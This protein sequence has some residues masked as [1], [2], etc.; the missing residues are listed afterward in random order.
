MSEG[1]PAGQALGPVMDQALDWHIRQRSGGWDGAEQAAFDAWRASDPAH[2]AAWRSVSAVWSS[3]QLGQAARL[4]QARLAPSSPAVRPR[5]SLPGWPWRRVSAIAAA[6]LVAAWIGWRFDLPT[7]LQADLVTGTG[8]Q[9]RLTLEDGSRLVLDTG[10]AIVAEMSGSRRRVRLLKGAA[11]FEVA[12]EQARPFEVRAGSAQVQ[13][14][15]T[16]FTVRYL[17]GRVTVAVRRGAVL[18]GRPGGG[19]VRLTAS[20]QVQVDAEG[21]G[22]VEGVDA[23]AAMAWVDG[24]LVFVDQPLRDVLSELRRYHPGLIILGDGRLGAARLTGNYRLDDPVQ[25]LASLAAILH[26]RM[27]RLTDAVLILH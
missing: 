23:A 10:T 22:P 1:R 13:V 15:G 21:V 4:A 27:T 6:A 12:S 2:E 14:T 20:Q 18:V 25:T 11:Y 16:A 7:R 24:R 9:E 26:A 19:T 17:D 5:R 3:P 8:H